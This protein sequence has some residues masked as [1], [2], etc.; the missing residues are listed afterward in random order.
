MASKSTYKQLLAYQFVALFL[1]LLSAQASFSQEIEDAAPEEQTTAVGKPKKIHF[2]GLV[3][4]VSGKVERQGAKKEKTPLVYG[5]V[6][7]EKERILLE[8]DAVAKLVMR[9]ACVGVFYGEGKVLAPAPGKPWQAINE[10]VRWLCPETKSPQLHLIKGQTIDVNGSEVLISG[11]RLLILRGEPKGA[12]LQKAKSLETY[13]LEKTGWVLVNP[14]PSPEDRFA[15]NARFKAPKESVKLAKPDEPKRE[16]PP[17]KTRILVGPFGGG[18]NFLHDV[19][20]QSDH[21]AESNGGRIQYH[22]QRGD[23]SLIIAVAPHSEVRDETQTYFN[24]PPPGESS[25]QINMTSLELGWR[26][27]HLRWWSPYVRGGLAHFSN[28]FTFR[29]VN[30][31]MSSGYYSYRYEHLGVNATVGIDAYF[32]PKFIPWFG[33][34]GGF[35]GFIARTFAK[36]G[37]PESDNFTNPNP[38]DWMG[39]N[40]TLTGAQ[41]SL[42]FIFQF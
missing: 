4:Y 8:K 5:D 13:S 39:Y 7:Y 3:Q 34:Y 9:N 40:Y 31:T 1:V 32:R 30:Q 28:R 35:E 24:H 6:V 20:A 37:D 25:A 10:A 14:Q 17:A 21:S 23:G 27:N 12:G 29:D 26:F 15:F 22:R 16:R 19:S 2:A 18:A 33:L 36:L 38:P 11:N 42:G 41:I